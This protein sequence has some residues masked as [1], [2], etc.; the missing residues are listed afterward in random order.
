[1]IVAVDAQGNR[2]YASADEEYE[3]SFCPICGERVRHKNKGKVKKPYFSHIETDNCQFGRDKDAKSQWHIRIQEYF[4]KEAREYIFRD[5]AT[6]EKHIA[7]VF[8]E[9]KNTVI[10]VQ[11]SRIDEA[12][13]IS[14]TAFHLNNGRRVVWLFDE[15]IESDKPNYGRFKTTYVEPAGVSISSIMLEPYQVRK[16][17]WLRNPRKMLTAVPNEYLHSKKYS[18]CVYTGTEGDVFHRIVKQ[19]YNYEEVVFSLHE[20]VMKEG[21][22]VDEFF[23]FESYWQN[24]EP[25]KE[26]FELRREL[27]EEARENIERLRIQ[28]I[29]RQMNDKSYYRRA[30]VRRGRRF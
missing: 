17:K 6:G 22:D 13:F 12:E 14:R 23:T 25:W 29:E 28:E 15:S 26:V 18:V 1:M 11:H 27:A 24:Q 19:E 4:P 21:I 5:E 8:L 3:E 9:D 2:I 7:D 30:P 10:E 20:I 16:Y